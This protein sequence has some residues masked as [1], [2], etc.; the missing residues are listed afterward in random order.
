MGGGLFGG[1]SQ[2]QKQQQSQN[3]N[4]NQ[5]Q[6]STSSASANANANAYNNL[7]INYPNQSAGMALQGLLGAPASFNPLGAPGVA[8]AQQG[9]VALPGYQAPAIAPVAAQPMP[10]APSGSIFPQ[11]PA[12]PAPPPPQAFASA[13]A[14]GAE[15]GGSAPSFPA[16]QQGALGAL[17]ALQAPQ[18]PSGS[19]VV[20]PGGSATSGGAPIIASAPGPAAVMSD[21]GGG[22]GLQAQQATMDTRPTDTAPPAEPRAV[23]EN[24]SAS[25]SNSPVGGGEDY[26]IPTQLPLT[27]R[28][29]LRAVYNKHLN[30]K[31]QAAAQPYFQDEAG[32]VLNY[33]QFQTRMGARIE[34]IDKRIKANDKTITDLQEITGDLG[35][36]AAQAELPYLKNNRGQ[37]ETDNLGRNAMRE[38]LSMQ[39]EARDY[40]AER[41]PDF[42]GQKG[43]PGWTRKDQQAL[44]IGEAMNGHGKLMTKIGILLHPEQ[45]GNAAKYV[46]KYQTALDKQRFAIEK[47]AGDAVQHIL[48]AHAEQRKFAL[49]AVDKKIAQLQHTNDLLQ[50][51]ADADRKRFNSSKLEESKEANAIRQAALQQAREILSQTNASATQAEHAAHDQAT[52]RLNQLEYNNRVDHQRYMEQVASFNAETAA[53]GE[54]I[55]EFLAPSRQAM[56]N[57]MAQ[58]LIPGQQTAPLP[59]YAPPAPRQLAPVRGVSHF[60]VND[61]PRRSGLVPPPPAYTPSVLPEAGYPQQSIMPQPG[62]SKASYMAQ[63]KSLV[64]RGPGQLTDAKAKLLYV[65]AVNSGEVR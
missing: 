8:Q 12:P 27:Q 64:G 49:D 31:R 58:P 57:N 5:S 52:E 17:Q 21:A 23:S 60:E 25:E 56:Y 2:S 30:A 29:Q 35:K 61:N 22:G 28:N 32:Q 13:P 18:S 37:L 41:V 42:A 53:R 63:L 40:A 10:V 19:M 33:N 55:N 39:D 34:E 45:P 44:D 47:E 6:T 7:T 11:L 43:R 3:Q 59:Q 36:A 4:Q 14:V 51:Q 38:A 9:E 26:Q 16:M 54:G 48:T 46:E 1:P 50:K 62:Q 65:D 20:L 15:N 24:A